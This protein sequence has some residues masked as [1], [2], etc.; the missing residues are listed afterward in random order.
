M[1]GSGEADHAAYH[2]RSRPI[3]GTFISYDVLCSHGV[4]PMDFRLLVLAFLVT[5][6]FE[7]PG[8]VVWGFI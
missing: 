7:A 1:D 5:L 4:F 2:G 8:R 6:S 3:L